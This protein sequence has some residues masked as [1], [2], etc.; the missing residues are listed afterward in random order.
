[1]KYIK[2]Y[3][4]LY[5]QCEKK[6][7]L[8]AG[9]TS[10]NFRGQYASLSCSDA[11]LSLLQHCITRDAGMALDNRLNVGA[12]WQHNALC[13]IVID[14]IS[15]ALG[16]VFPVSLDINIWQVAKVQ[17]LLQT[18][19]DFRAVTSK[20]LN[21]VTSTT[22]IIRFQ[23]N[24]TNQMFLKCRWATMFCRII[25]FF[26][27]TCTTFMLTHHAFRWWNYIDINER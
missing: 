12:D 17:A 9:P 16:C 8:L 14:F 11:S 6:R 25:S 15:I 1:M 4:Q 18:E 2:H 3:I 10:S 22:Q 27:Y 23:I 13:K 26:K 5:K 21:S 7:N 20:Y 19:W 24:Y